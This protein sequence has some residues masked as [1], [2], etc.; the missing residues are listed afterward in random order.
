MSTPPPLY[1]RFSLRELRDRVRLLEQLSAFL[2]DSSD[3]ENRLGL[4][5]QK[6]PLP[7]LPLPSLPLTSYSTSTL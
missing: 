6:V 2:E 1:I 3:L 7:R 5:W 4:N